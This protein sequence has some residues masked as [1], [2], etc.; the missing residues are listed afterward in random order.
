VSLGAAAVRLF[1]WLWAVEAA[2]V[3]ILAGIYKAPG[4]RLTLLSTSSRVLLVAGGL[5]LAGSGWLLARQIATSGP[6][7]GR[8]FALAL[9]AN[10]VTGVLALSLLEG[11][12][13]NAAR[14]TP[15]GLAVGAVDI[16]P[17]GP[18]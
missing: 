9:G 4:L 2:T 7:R 15:D 11:A 8:A 6:R 13:R 10:L 3:A 16:R 14:P 17:R 18:S 12:V 5:G 1:G